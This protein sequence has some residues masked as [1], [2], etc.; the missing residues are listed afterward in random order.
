[1]YVDAVDTLP[2]RKWVRRFCINFRGGGKNDSCFL[3]HDLIKS[4]SM[5]H[6]AFLFHGQNVVQCAIKYVGLQALMHSAVSLR[7]MGGGEGKQRIAVNQ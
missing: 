1:M 3:W 5:K 7:G 2:S 4:D 6:L